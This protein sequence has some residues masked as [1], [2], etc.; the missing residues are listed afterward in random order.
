MAIW[1][2]PVFAQPAAPPARQGEPAAAKPAAPLPALLEP[3]AGF[4]VVFGPGGPRVLGP[5]AAPQVQAMLL[6]PGLDLGSPACQIGDVRIEAR[7]LLVQ[8]SCADGKATAILAVREPGD[9]GKNSAATAWFSLALPPAWQQPAAAE[10]QLARTAAQ[11]ELLKRVQAG[12]AKLPWQRVRPAPGS[13]ADAWMTA[14][15]LAQRAAATGDLPGARSALLQAKAVRPLSELRPAELFDFALLS[16]ASAE[17]VLLQEVLKGLETKL[18]AQAQPTSQGFAGDDAAELRALAAAIPALAGDPTSTVTKANSCLSPPG[19]DVLPAVRALAASRAYAQAADVL[20]GGPLAGQGKVAFDLLKL[21]FGLASA[22][23]DAAVEL[24]IAERMTVEHPEMAEGLDL[25][26]AGLG[27]AGRYREAIE[28]LHELSQRHADRDIV[29]GRIAGLLAFLTAEALEDP[30]KKAELE[31]VE[32]RMR[33]AAQRNN[34]IVARFIV[35]TR[36][37]YAGEFTKALPELQ[38]LAATANR[39]PRIPLYLAM[40][41]FWLGHQADA[42]KWIGKAVQIGPSD[43]DVFYCR[44]QIVRRSNLPLA[45]A[46]LERYEAMT[47]QPWALGPRQKTERVEAELALMRKGRIPPDWDKPGPDRAVFLPAEQTGTAAS[48]LAIRGPNGAGAAAN[49]AESAQ[50]QATATPTQGENPQPLSGQSPKTPWTLIGL[51]AAI[52]AALGLRFVRAR[53]K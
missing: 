20:D 47:K 38:A 40:A 43:P 5:D 36:G 15:L 39:D 17:K 44:S 34:D 1:A 13:P 4:D 14:L 32:Q 6:E 3:Y 19:C 25:R 42:E 9:Q 50:P 24:A 45:I 52:A 7:R 46:D 33:E 2:V 53:R 30:S 18:A 12:E 48:E 8:I 28:I 51:G 21:R 23:N 10:L 35:A 29:L 11:A 49:T 16:V 37:Y 41:H 31:L 22:L 26:A 27:R